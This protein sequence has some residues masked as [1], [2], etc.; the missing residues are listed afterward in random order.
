MKT[1]TMSGPELALIVGTRVALG[2]GIGLL[3]A[4]KLDSG[5]RR[6]A[7]AALLALGA[8]STIPLAMEVLSHSVEPDSGPGSDEFYDARQAA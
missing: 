4:G 8:L 3:L 7:G 5:A 1:A 6:G 2:I